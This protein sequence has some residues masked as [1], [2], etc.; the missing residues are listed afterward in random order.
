MY[1]SNQFLILEFQFISLTINKLYFRCKQGNGTANKGRNRNS[2]LTI[3]KEHVYVRVIPTSPALSLTLHLLVQV[4]TMAKQN[5]S[6][7]L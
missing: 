7:Q 5:S 2:N 6:L 3:F 1:P 4:P